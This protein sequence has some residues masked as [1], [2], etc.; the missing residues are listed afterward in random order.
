MTKKVVATLLAALLALGLFCLHVSA[1]PSAADMAG[2]AP[3]ELTAEPIPDEN[4]AAR[5]TFKIDGLGADMPGME[6]G[7]DIHVKLEYKLGAGVWEPYYD[8]GSF[9]MLEGFQRSPGVFQFRFAWVLGSEWDG[10]EPVLFRVYCEY[11]QGG[12]VGTDIISGYS[13]EA[14]IGVAGG[15]ETPSQAEESTLLPKEPRDLE[16]PEESSGAFAI[17]LVFLLWIG[18][19]LLLLLLVIIIIVVISRKKKRNA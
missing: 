4:G 13:N 6:P 7:D 1:A 3:Y 15:G 14:I 9:E 19:G 5:L 16:Q 17:S 8:Y 11:M 12:N 10:V 2:L 18:G